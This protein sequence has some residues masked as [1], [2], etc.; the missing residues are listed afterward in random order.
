MKGRLSGN[1]NLKRF[2]ETKGVIRS[3]KSKNILYN[4]KKKKG[5]TVVYITL[6]KKLEIEE[7]EPYYN[8]PHL[9][10]YAVRR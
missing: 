9:Q 5:Q 10:N 3:R 2:V 6:H 4:G 7:N 1:Y 8:I